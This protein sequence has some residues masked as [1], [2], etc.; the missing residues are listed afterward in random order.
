MK[1]HRMGKS[2]VQ[3]F[4][5]PGSPTPCLVLLRLRLV[6]VCPLLPSVHLRF[7]QEG[8][9][10][11]PL[12]SAQGTDPPALAKEHKDGCVFRAR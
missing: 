6:H 11:T 3:G 7:Q 5:K 1:K 4:W 8:W 9:A 2:F 12:I 10:P